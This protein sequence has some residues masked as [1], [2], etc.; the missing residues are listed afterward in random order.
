M[1]KQKCVKCEFPRPQTI[2][3]LRPLG[4]SPRPVLQLNHR[5]I[6][7]ESRWVWEHVW[8]SKWHGQVSRYLCEYASACRPSRAPGGGRPGLPWRGTPPK[9]ALLSAQIWSGSHFM[10]LTLSSWGSSSWSSNTSVPGLSFVL[11]V[12]GWEP[13]SGNYSTCQGGGCRLPSPM[14]CWNHE[15]DRV[16]LTRTRTDWEAGSYGGRERRPGWSWLQRLWW[17]QRGVSQRLRLTGGTGASTLPPSPVTILL[18]DSSLPSPTPSGWYET[19]KKRC[20]QD[21][22]NL[23]IREKNRGVSV[24]G[25][26]Q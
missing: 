20:T 25:R 17:K 15:L 24:R 16:W 6:N 14:H 18:M 22:Y 11:S 10:E 7:R 23:L 13:G 19:W 4:P 26:H 12:P 3:K 9:P 1:L 2:R 8:V 21:V 5:A